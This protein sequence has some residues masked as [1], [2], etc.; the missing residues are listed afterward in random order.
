MQGPV[1]EVQMR[2]RI[3]VHDS[4]LI[5]QLRNRESQ[6]FPSSPAQT[7]VDRYIDDFI[8]KAIPDGDSLD[9][10]RQVLVMP[11]ERCFAPNHPVLFTFGQ[12]K[13]LAQK[14][15]D[16]VWRHAIDFIVVG[17]AHGRVAL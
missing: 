14:S 4:V 6:Q 2:R 15:I 3:A 10:F 7:P 17:F 16:L 13:F 1:I 8:I 11:D 12:L 9:S 5:P